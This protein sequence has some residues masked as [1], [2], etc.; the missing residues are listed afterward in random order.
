MNNRI[1]TV[2]Q[3]NELTSLIQEISL[4]KTGLGIDGKDCREPI[5]EICCF[6]ETRLDYDSSCLVDE[7]PPT[8]NLDAR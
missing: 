2:S 7:P 8:S 1:I 6:F 4:E 3:Q 5:H